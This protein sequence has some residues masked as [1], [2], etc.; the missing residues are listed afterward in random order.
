[1]ELVPRY[2]YRRLSKLPTT[3]EEL[4]RHTA[5][6]LP[7][8]LAGM[9]FAHTVMPPGA[10]V[11]ISVEDTAGVLIFTLSGRGVMLLDG[12]RVEVGA[13]DLVHVP[14]HVPYGLRT[15]G[16]V[17]WTYVVLQAPVE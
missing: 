1:M 2:T 3:V 14:P 8:M 16:G 15:L 5:L 4:R 11:P 10:T 17:D 7:G 9:S 13:N 12:D 6:N